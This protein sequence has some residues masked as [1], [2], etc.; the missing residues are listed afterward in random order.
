M[1]GIQ[2]RVLE[3]YGL[4]LLFCIEDT[5]M[6]KHF[7]DLKVVCIGRE[8]N[9]DC[10]KKPSVFWSQIIFSLPENDSF[11]FLI[12]FCHFQYI[13][14]CWWIVQCRHVRCPFF[15]VYYFFLCALLTVYAFQPCFILSHIAFFQFVNGKKKTM[16]NNKKIKENIIQMT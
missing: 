15:V 10:L 6:Q 5:H 2:I 7:V 3:K 9:I 14:F 8:F 16:T 11:F 12:L 4:V 13:A 1:N